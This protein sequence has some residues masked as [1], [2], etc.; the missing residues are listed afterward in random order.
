MGGIQKVGNSWRARWTDEWGIRRSSYHA[1]KREAELCLRREVLRVEEVKL[2]LRLGKQ[3]EKTVSE[4]CDDWEVYCAPAKRSYK[5]DISIIERHLRPFFG[6]CPLRSFSIELVDRYRASRRHLADK[7]VWNHLTLLA[8]MLNRAHE[9]R[10]IDRP[11]RIRK[12]KLI[13][14]PSQYR[15]LK[16]K[17][18]VRR[19]LEAARVEGQHVFILY[20]A[21]IFTGMRAGEL[22]GL[23]WGDVDFKRRLL[24]VQRSYDGP[25]KSGRLRRIPIFDVLVAHMQDWAVTRLSTEWVFP[26]QAGRMLGKSARITQ[27]VLH[28][29]LRQAG[30]TEETRGKR[31]IRYVTFHSFRHTFASHFMMNGGDVFILQ[32]LLGHQSIET[33]MRYAHLAPDAFAGEYGRFAGFGPLQAGEVINLKHERVTRLGEQSQL[34]SRHQSSERWET[35][36]G[37]GKDIKQRVRDG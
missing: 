31:T 9:L 18:E 37:R 34:P 16:T 7:T 15:Y 26:N 2:G 5:D 28:R 25:T 11:I 29:V 14:N 30:F 24:T 23:Q 19:L 32:R 20:S 27:E 17:G 3:P 4:L 1:T 13:R 36:L 33:T 12:P 6:D 8:A 35:T 22:A 21:A 10:W